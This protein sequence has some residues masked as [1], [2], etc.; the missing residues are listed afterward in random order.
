[1]LQQAIE[2]EIEGC[3]AAERRERDRRL[4]VD[5]RLRDA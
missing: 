5:K 4:D 2:A 1:M 3:L